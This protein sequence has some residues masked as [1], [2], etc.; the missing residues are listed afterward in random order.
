MSGLRSKSRSAAVVVIAIAIRGLAVT[1]LSFA[2]TIAVSWWCLW[3]PGALQQSGETTPTPKGMV[4]GYEFRG[5]DECA[6]TLFGTPGGFEERA[7]AAFQFAT[8]EEW[9]GK[10]SL[11]DISIRRVD[12]WEIIIAGWPR[13][14]LWYG[15]SGGQTFGGVEVPKWLPSPSPRVRSLPTRVL[16]SG[17]LINSALVAPVWIGV[18]LLPGLVRRRRRRAAGLCLR[19]GYDLKGLP[20]GTPCPECGMRV[21]PGLAVADGGAIIAPDPQGSGDK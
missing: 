4:S 11:M 17:M 5:A 16:W 6:V 10:Q 8:T 1:A 2:T 7:I 13:R 12:F 19:C 14:A 3:H 20:N 21:K 18:V 15:E 9:R